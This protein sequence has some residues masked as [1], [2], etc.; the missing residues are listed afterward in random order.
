M[1]AGINSKR[2]PQSIGEEI[3][4][5]ISHG[6]GAALAV[7]GTA[8]MITCAC[9]AGT[10]ID[11]V[12]ASLY[13]FSMVFLFLIS[14]LYHALTNDRAKKVFQVL[15]HC[16][17][18]ILII[19][20]YTPICLSLFGGALGWTLFGI[21]LALAATGVS[22]TAVD[23][24]KFKRLSMIMYILIG[25]SVIFAVKPLLSLIPAHGFALL[26]AGGLFYTVGIVFYKAK[27]PKFMHS[28]WHLMVLAGSVLHYFFI[29]LYVILS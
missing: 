7:A 24:V 5:S 1:D 25:W 18:F 19:G 23:M 26:L 14:T 6:V 15:D 12:S 29:L 16:S 28:V 9:F 20:T 4:N 21:D 22:L 13:G 11:I 8:V 3:A 17:I 10:A 27:R 2:I